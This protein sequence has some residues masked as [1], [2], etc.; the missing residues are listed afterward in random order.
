M[1]IRFHEKLYNDGLSDRKLA[2]IQKKIKKKSPKLNLFLITLP[3][4]RQGLLEV[5][6]YPELLQPFYQE[7]DVEVTVVGVAYTRED[8]F[9]LI[10]EIVR[11]AGIC[12]GQ[13]SIGSFFE[14][15]T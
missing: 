4:G 5:Y 6:W 10:E 13:I 14:E 15:K 12:A 1:D 9:S 3:V 2:S 11:D 7:M 8:A